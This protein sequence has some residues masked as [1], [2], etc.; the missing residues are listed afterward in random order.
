MCIINTTELFLNGCFKMA[1]RLHP[2]IKYIGIQ[3]DTFTK[4]SKYYLW[5]LFE[6]NGGK[7]F[8]GFLKDF[9]PQFHPS[10]VPSMHSIKISSKF[11]YGEL[12]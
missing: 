5:I 1:N 10:G 4:N 3:K 11:R 9:T 6:K 7:K 2:P 8:W 12:I